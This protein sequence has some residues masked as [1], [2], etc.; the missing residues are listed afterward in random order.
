[1]ESKVEECEKSG[2]LV[3]NKFEKTKKE[4]KSANDDLKRLNGKCKDFEKAVNTM[5]TK[6][7]NT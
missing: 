1:M 5:E 2:Q 3:S 7:Q 4:L 6:K